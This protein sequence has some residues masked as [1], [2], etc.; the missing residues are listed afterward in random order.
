MTSATNPHA[1]RLVLPILVDA[2]PDA[3]FSSASGHP[4]PAGAPSL[5]TRRPLLGRKARS[6]SLA[7]SRPSLFIQRGACA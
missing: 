7:T 6:P 5:S 1:R 3:V 4:L 2:R